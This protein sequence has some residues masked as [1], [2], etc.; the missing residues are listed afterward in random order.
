MN[1]SMELK[2]EFNC[3]LDC[4]GFETTDDL[5]VFLD[6]LFENKNWDAAQKV[7][8]SRLLRDRKPKKSEMLLVSIPSA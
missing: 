7:N 8:S 2:N 4:R 6:A 3:P 1:N 5:Q